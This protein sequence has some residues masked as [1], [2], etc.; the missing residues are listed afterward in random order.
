MTGLKRVGIFLIAFV[1]FFFF[2]SLTAEGTDTYGKLF[3]SF[4]FGLGM[5]LIV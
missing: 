4:I 5:A 1:V 2:V 3:W